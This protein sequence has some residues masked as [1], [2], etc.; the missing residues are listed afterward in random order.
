MH[1]KIRSYSL[2]TRLHESNALFIHIMRN[3]NHIIP[4]YC[5][6]PVSCRSLVDRCG[7]FGIC[8][9]QILFFFNIFFSEA[10]YLLIFAMAID[11]KWHN[12]LVAVTYLK[13]YHFVGFKNVRI[14][15]PSF[16]TVLSSNSCC[17]CPVGLS[18]LIHF[19]QVLWVLKL[20]L[21]QHPQDLLKM[22]Y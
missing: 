2:Q 11:A 17:F 3:A 8:K 22:L 19:Q 13:I 5:Y 1:E 16:S 18:L 21:S 6:L 4:S 14:N 20:L 12:Q 9:P 15:L 7:S 10:K